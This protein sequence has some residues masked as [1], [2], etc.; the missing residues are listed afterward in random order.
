MDKSLSS[1]RPPH[2]YVGDT[3]YIITTSTV[4]RARYLS[5]DD[6]LRLCVEVIRMLAQEFGIM[7]CAWVVLRN[8]YHLLLKSRVGQ[9]IGRFIG[10]LN[11]RTSREF[12][13]L[14][15]AKGRQVWYSYWDTCI[16]TEADLWT[17]FNYIHNNPVK[18]G[19]ARHHADWEFSS[20]RYYLRTRG[21]EWLADCWQRHPV[22]DYLE[23]DDL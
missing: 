8:H 21:E 7:L 22:N 20:Y 11:G 3:W 10:R 18:H 5:T 16:R 13:R 2:I 15:N 12:N 23:G 19:Y 1:H 14:D 6:H 9:D 17:R 4:N